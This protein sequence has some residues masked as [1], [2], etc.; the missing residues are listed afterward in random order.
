MLIKNN[1]RLIEE[2]E[3]IKLSEL[4]IGLIDD[5]LPL[6]EKSDLQFLKKMKKSFKVEGGMKEFNDWVAP[7]IR[8]TD[9]MKELT[10]RGFSEQKSAFLL[11]VMSR[12]QKEEKNDEPGDDL[13]IDVLW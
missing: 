9:Q 5:V 2:K 13:G 11:W 12:P 1:Y 3:E 8:D 10:R 4:D 6:K 7:E